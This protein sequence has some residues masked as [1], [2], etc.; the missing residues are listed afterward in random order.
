MG[1]ELFMSQ[2][3]IAT[4]IFYLSFLALISMVTFF[5]YMADKNKAQNGAYRIPEKV[6]LLFSLLGGAFGG[7]PAMLIFRHKTKGEHWYF[8]FCEHP[9]D[10]HP[11]R[12]NCFNNYCLF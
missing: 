9:W 4:L 6:L 12:F 7:F 10:T 8:I 3:Q 11:Y 1:E 5:L 2:I